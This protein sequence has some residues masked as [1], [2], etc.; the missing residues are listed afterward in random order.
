MPNRPQEEL[1]DRTIDF[2]FKRLFASDAHSPAL[3]DLVNAVFGAFNQPLIKSLTVLNPS[4]DPDHDGDKT[5][6]LDIRAVTQDGH[7]I[8]VEMQM[9]D[10]GHFIRRMLY[11]WA[12]LY[13]ETLHAG[14]DYAVLNRTITINFLNFNLFSRDRMIS[15]NQLQDSQDHVL[16]TDLQQIYV[17][18]LPKLGRI[19]IPEHLQQWLKF[20]TISNTQELKRLAQQNPAIG[21]AYKMLDYISQDPEERRRH[22]SRKMAQMDMRSAISTAEHRGEVLVLQRQL[23]KRFGPLSDWALTKLTT[24]TTEQLENWSEKILDAPPSLE[25]FFE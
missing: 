19:P 7:G 14:Q 15:L 20:L 17:I 25:A 24:A 3:L 23:T 12:E 8:N 18:E 16:L 2:V 11:Y 1:L 10:S 9:V 5:A 13:G 21:E 6:I 22:L 4:L